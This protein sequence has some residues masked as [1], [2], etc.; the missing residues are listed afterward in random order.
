MTRDQ[1]V[2]TDQDIPDSYE[3]MRTVTCIKCATDFNII[4][5]VSSADY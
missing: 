5:H 1:A 4:H 2:R 3:V